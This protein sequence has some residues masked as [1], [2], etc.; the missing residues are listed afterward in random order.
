MS[1]LDNLNKR[2]E[3][4]GGRLQE[5]R[6][7]DGK[8]RTLKKALLYSYQAETAIIDGKEF[9]CLINP[10]KVNVDYDNKILSIPFKDICL[11]ADK[12]GTTTE[13]QVDINIKA[14]DVFTWKETN[15][16]WIVYLRHIEENAYFRAEIRK[17]QSIAEINGNKYKVYK[18]N[19][20]ILKIDWRE[21]SRDSL[22]NTL[23]YTA[24]MYITKND[25][26]SNYLKRFAKIKVDDRPW[27]VQAARLK[28]GIIEVALKEDFSNTLEEEMNTETE[29]GGSVKPELPHILGETIVYPYETYTYTIE[30]TDSGIWSI[31]NMKVARINKQDSSQVEISIVTG[32]SGNFILNYTNN[33]IT[34]PLSIKIES[35]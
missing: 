29:S 23:N 14:G 12:I 35:I 20:D 6:M 24:I 1:G 31:D 26:T 13:G 32:R 27:E 3:Y 33:M 15:T 22:F 16:D 30:G 34:I 7:Q 4:A 17:C 28:D 9:R 5:A 11:N 18:N 19:S 10:D 21:L 25:E 2:L 8:L